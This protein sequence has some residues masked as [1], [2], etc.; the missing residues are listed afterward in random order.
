VGKAISSRLDRPRFA[1]Y[2]FGMDKISNRTIFWFSL[3]ASVFTVIAGFLAGIDYATNKIGSRSYG[4][5]MLLATLLT[6]VVYTIK[7]VSELIRRN[8]SLKDAAEMLE[9]N[10]T[11]SSE[12][13]ISYLKGKN[14]QT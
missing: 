6:S 13:G 3:N 2:T 12:S 8:N 11:G 1:K 5:A 7:M 14:T 9:R 4:I 10:N